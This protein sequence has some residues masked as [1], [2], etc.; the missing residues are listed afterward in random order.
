MGTCESLFRDKIYSPEKTFTPKISSPHNK[1]FSPKNLGSNYFHTPIGNNNISLNNYSNISTSQSYL[2]FTSN[3][4]NQKPSLL[5][6]QNMST[7]NSYMN[8]SSKLNHDSMSSGQEYIVEGKLNNNIEDDQGFN[9]F[10]QQ[11]NKDIDAII[12]ENNN[13]NNENEDMNNMNKNVIKKDVNVY[14]HKIN[15]NNK[16]NKKKKKKNNKELNEI[17]ELKNEDVSEGI[18]IPL[19]TV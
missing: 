4:Q 12:E 18:P 6:Y 10:M 15:G 19:D 17:Q 9:H 5:V 8:G 16:S 1:V 2:T 13:N 14:H 7:Q 11:K 3:N